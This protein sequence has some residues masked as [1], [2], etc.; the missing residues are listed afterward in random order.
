MFDGAPKVKS[1]IK[2]QIKIKIKSGSLRI[3]VRVGWC[4]ALSIP[5]LVAGM[6]APAREVVSEEA[7]E[8][9]GDGGFDAQDAGAQLHGL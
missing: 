3:V 1:Q 2:S 9:G 6:S 5:M 4:N 8:Q 7:G